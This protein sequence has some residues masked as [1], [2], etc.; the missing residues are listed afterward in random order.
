ACTTDIEIPVILPGRSLTSDDDHAFAARVA[1]DK[2]I[3]LGADRAAVLDPQLASAC[4]TDI[5]IPTNLPSRVGAGD[6]AGAAPAGREVIADRAAVLDRQLAGPE[7]TDMEISAIR[8]GRAG[9]GHGNGAVAV[10]FPADI[11]EVIADRAAI[12]DR[13]LAGADL[14]DSEVAVYVP[15]VWPINGHRNRVAVVDDFIALHRPG[16]QHQG[17]RGDRRQQQAGATLFALRT[18]GALGGHHQAS[19]TLRPAK[20]V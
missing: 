3:D 8:P 5:E 1:A 11:T 15:L 12:L 10:R 17:Q 7:L 6:S 14:A 2:A 16:A 13:Q 4:T 18:L 20:P 9:A 19:Q